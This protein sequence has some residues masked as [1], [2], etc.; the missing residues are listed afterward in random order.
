MSIMLSTREISTTSPESDEIISRMNHMNLD[1]HIGTGAMDARP[2]RIKGSTL[3]RNDVRRSRRFVM[4]SARKTDRT[5]PKGARVPW[6]KIVALD[7]SAVAPL[8]PSQDLIGI[9][10]YGRETYSK[11]LVTEF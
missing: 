8:N 4:M 9:S 5:E 2:E 6:K 1:G 3:K 7:A 10:D 11:I